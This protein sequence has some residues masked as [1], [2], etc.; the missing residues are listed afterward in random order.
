MFAIVFTVCM[1]YLVFGLTR[2]VGADET[3]YETS[4]QV[5]WFP[6]SDARGQANLALVRFAIEDT[7]GSHGPCSELVPALAGGEPWH[8]SAGPMGNDR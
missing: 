6:A 7:K 1:K 8:L 4:G 2:H 5:T 3:C